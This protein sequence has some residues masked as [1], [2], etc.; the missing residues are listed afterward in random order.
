[1]EY[2]AQSLHNYTTI[3]IWGTHDTA[4]PIEDAE[5]IARKVNAT[6]YRIEEG[7]HFPFL[8]NTEDEFKTVFKK[9]IA[10]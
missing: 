6:I 3:F 2:L 5:T 9:S 1:M 8:G 7:D 4:A 10:L